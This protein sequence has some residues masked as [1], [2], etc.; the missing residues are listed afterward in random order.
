MVKDSDSSIIK[1]LS[2][3]VALTRRKTLNQMLFKVRA[4]LAL[5]AAGTSRELSLEA[6]AVV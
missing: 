5:K 3:N 1:K 2:K 4:G 6:V